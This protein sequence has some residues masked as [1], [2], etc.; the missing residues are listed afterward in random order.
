[1]MQE[2]Y[3]I[4]MMGE[5][6]FFLGLQIHQQRNGIFISQEKYLKDFLKKFGMEDCK[7]YATP[8]VKSSIKG[9]PLMIGSLPY[10][11][12]SRPDIM[13]S[14][15]MC[16]RFQA[17]PKESHHLAV[18]R[19]LRYLAY[20]PTLGLWYPK[21]SEFDLVGFSYA[22][23]V[24]DKVDCKSTSGTFLDDLLSAGLQ[25]SR[26]VYHSPLLNLNTLLLDLAALS[27]SR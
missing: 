11:C 12:A 8:M 19:I 4:S 17:A 3:Q 27:F 14:I 9:I 22:D 15:C 20:T 25:R 21:G 5:L 6:K 24:G 2:Q 26:T 16:A 10:L 23:Y 13:L 1:M 18:K 7:G